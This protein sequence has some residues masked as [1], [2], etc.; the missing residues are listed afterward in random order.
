MIE[1]KCVVY[2]IHRILENDILTQGYVGISK[3]PYRRFIE[4]R[5]RHPNWFFEDT[6]CQIIIISNNN[7]CKHVE[8]LLRPTSNIG[9]NKAPGGGQ[10]PNAKG[11]KRSEKTKLL[12]SKNNV[13]IVGKFHSEETKLKMSRNRKGRIPWNRGIKH[14]DEAKK[15]MSLSRTG[16]P[17]SIEHRNSISKSTKGKPKSEEHKRKLSETKKVRLLLK[18]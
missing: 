13:G 8:K 6:I 14:T 10:P 16:K 4:H 11:L 15:K 9:L 3:D 7:Y 18:G 2:W 17:L 12:L 1:N 5:K